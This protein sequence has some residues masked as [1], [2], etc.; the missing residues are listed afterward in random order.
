[1]NQWV[2]SLDKDVY[3]DDADFFRPE[4][5]LRG[6]DETAAA[7]EAR[8]KMMKEGDLSFGGGNRICTGRHMASL[9]MFKVTATL[10]SRY[11][12]SN[13]ATVDFQSSDHSDIH[14]FMLRDF[15]DGAQRP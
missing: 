1:M 11:E 2:I 9:E 15:T 13:T 12:V 4:R 14:Y 3:G 6:D 5:W 10:F 7:Y 8:L